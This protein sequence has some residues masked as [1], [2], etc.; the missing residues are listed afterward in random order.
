MTDVTAQLQAARNA[1]YA[2]AALSDAQR[3]SVLQTLSETLLAD[4]ARI[5]AENE[6]DL[7]LMPKY[8]PRYDR[9]QLTPQRLAGIAADIKTVAALPCPLGQVQLQR[10]MPNGLHIE[11]IAVPLGVVGVIY[12]SRPNVTVD[13]FALCFKAGNACALKGGKEAHH[14]NAALMA[15]IAKALAKHGIEAGAACLLPPERAAAETLMNATGLVDVL[16]PRGSQG[17]IDAVRKNSRV[18]VIETGA[19]IVHTYFDATGDVKKGQKIIH[20]AKTRRVSVCNALDTLVVHE[21]RIADI[22]DLVSPMAAK[23]VEIFAD[24]DAYKS[25]NGKYP[26]QL[27]HHATE[28]SFGCEFLSYKMS[29]KTVPSL[30]A[31]LAHIRDHS[32]RHSEAIVSEHKPS[33][34]RFLAEVDAA[35]VYA[36]ASTAFTDGGQF[37]MGAE[38]GISTQKLHARGPM[39]L[40]ALTSYKWVVRGDGQTRE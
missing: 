30:D 29:I 14:S 26:A 39:G 7:A 40:E 23:D 27:L 8:D 38:I 31:A 16:I 37:G 21:S 13:V 28:E 5:L 11:R 18:P 33:I 9:L 24:T 36:N 25:L 1:T 10:D 34:D 6:K 2:L 3:N 4:Q 12:E 32:S 17:L 22:Y 19:G 35:A 15:C 20:N